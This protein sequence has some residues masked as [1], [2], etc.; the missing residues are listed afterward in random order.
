MPVSLTDIICH[1]RL[2]RV[3][4]IEITFASFDLPDVQ[5]GVK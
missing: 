2:A 4:S 5:I 3:K 1:F